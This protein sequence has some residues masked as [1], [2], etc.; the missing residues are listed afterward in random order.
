MQRKTCWHVSE[1]VQIQM[2]TVAYTLEA[3]FF[4]KK[5]LLVNVLVHLVFKTRN[6]KP[7]ELSVKKRKHESL[8]FTN[9]EGFTF[10]G[11]WSRWYLI[12]QYFY[13]EN[14]FSFCYEPMGAVPRLMTFFLYTIEAYH[15]LFL[16]LWI[17][18]CG[19]THD[20][21]G[22]RNNKNSIQKLSQFSLW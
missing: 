6:I 20:S 18:L 16:I 9:F 17:R 11:I 1:S 8:N 13:D 14:Y 10:P 12:K 3:F 22:K 4:N 7:E 19:E 15:M 5:R 2:L 21:N